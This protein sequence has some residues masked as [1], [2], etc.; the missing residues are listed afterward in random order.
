M[1]RI[2][3]IPTLNEGR[4]IVQTL[5]QLHRETVIVVD[6]GSTDDTVTKAKAEGSE[7]LKYRPG[8]GDQIIAGLKLALARGAEQIVVMD[9]ESHTFAEIE[10]HLS[11]SFDILAGV[12]VREEKP[13]LRKV[14]SGVGRFV[15]RV[16][17]G[18]PIQDPSNGFRG[19]SRKA[20]QSIIDEYEDVEIPAYAFNYAIAMHPRLLEGVWRVRHF[21]MTYNGGQ[22]GLNGKKLWK[23]A[24]WIWRHML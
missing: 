10:P 5:S 12:R 11:E 3:V 14:I 18:S 19:Y 23:A 13:L 1:K 16:C 9:A 24:L 6:G 15:A 8:Y 17:I 20:A 21:D 2:V 22:S 7:V 4:T